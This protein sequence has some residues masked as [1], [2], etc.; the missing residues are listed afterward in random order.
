MDA[1][2]LIER[3][4]RARFIAEETEGPSGASIPGVE[5]EAA[6]MFGDALRSFVAGNFLA[7][8][9]SAQA[10]LEH[11][12]ATA[13][14]TRGELNKSRLRFCDLINKCADYG[15]VDE[16]LANNL[17]RLRKLRNPYAHRQ[18]RTPDEWP[19]WFYSRVM[20]E[21]DGQP[22]MLAE[23]DAK[24]ALRCVVDY[25]RIINPDWVPPTQMEN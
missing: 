3:K 5:F 15:L 2:T 13:L 19:T 14:D 7:T 24:F 25:I 11:C 12:L 4:Q 22:Y 10:F 9:L 20:S 6:M 18:Q 23:I 17:H 16:A 1:L 21:A 8:V